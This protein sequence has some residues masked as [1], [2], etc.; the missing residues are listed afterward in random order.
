MSIMVDLGIYSIIHTH[1]DINYIDGILYCIKFVNKFIIIKL[2]IVI[3]WQYE[4]CI[5]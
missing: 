5:S 2:L 3:Y 4:F 1:I